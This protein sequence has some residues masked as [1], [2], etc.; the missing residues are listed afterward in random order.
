L[1]TPI[2][3]GKVDSVVKRKRRRKKE[4]GKELVWNPQSGEKKGKDAKK[5]GILKERRVPREGRMFVGRLGI[6]GE[7]G[8]GLWEKATPK[9]ENKMK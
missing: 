8:K 7:G 1:K 3:I 2:T 6:S 4:T 5:K 9:L